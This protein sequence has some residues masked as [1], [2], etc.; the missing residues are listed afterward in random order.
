MTNDESLRLMTLS[1][2]VN[3]CPICNSSA[4]FTRIFP[5]HV[6]LCR[7]CKTYFMNPR[8]TEQDITR[9]YDSGVTYNEWA[10]ET[11]LR[12]VMWRRR[13]RLVLYYKKNGTLLD[14]G[15]GDG[16]FLNIAREAGF[17]CTGTEISVNGA[18]RAK[19]QGHRVLVGNLA[20]L[21]FG[22]QSFDMIT[23]WHV[24]EHL[25]DPFATAAKVYHL[26][27]PGGVLLCAVPNESNRLIKRFLTGNPHPFGDGT[28]TPDS[29]IHLTYFQP[30]TLKNLLRIAGFRIIG[31]GV[32]DIYL[33]RPMEKRLKIAVHKII[34]R[35]TGWHG[36]LAMWVA[37]VSHRPWIIERL[38]EPV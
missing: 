7:A 35:F 20:D 18:H 30:R 15:T 2:S 24:F 11:T 6:V 33:Q 3:Q 5:P 12:N 27:K 4:S 32:D 14:I 31:F 34:C 36:G 26:L 29:E 21:E 25:S 9:H 22:S 38:E 23:G 19:E 10:K 37:A 13:M 1:E 16:V 17:E 28:F 8:P